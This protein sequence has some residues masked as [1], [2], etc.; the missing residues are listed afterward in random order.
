MAS[1]QPITLYSSLNP[2]AKAMIGM[3]WL[4]RKDG[5]GAT[6]HFESCGFIR[7]R[8]GIPYPDIQYHF[9]PMAV[10]YDGTVD[11]ERARLP[12]PCRA[13][14]VEEPRPG[15]AALGRPARGAADP[16]QLHDPSRRLDRDAR[17]RSADARDLRPAGLRPLSRRARS[18]RA[19]RSRTM[20]R[21]TPS[22]P[23]TSKAPITPPGPAGW[24][25]RATR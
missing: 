23:S 9:L 4:M 15:D 22:S 17:L 7:S 1:R 20:P 2:F 18:S 19:P 25:T 14:A 3:R 5:L 8:S 21:S 16:L 13:D 24:A 10:R 6:N 11:G 12:G